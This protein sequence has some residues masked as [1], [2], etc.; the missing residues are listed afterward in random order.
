MKTILRFKGSD[1]SGNH[2][3]AGR[4]GHRGGSAPGRRGTAAPKTETTSSTLE[5]H[6]IAQAIQIA[7]EIADASGG[8]TTDAGEAAR[9]FGERTGKTLTDSQV[10]QITNAVNNEFRVENYD[11]QLVEEKRPVAAATTV[12]RP[13]RTRE[14][15][16]IVTADGIKNGVPKSVM[17]V[18]SWDVHR[19]M[20]GPDVFTFGK[21]FYYRSG[22]PEGFAADVQDQLAQADLQGEIIISGEHYYPGFVGGAK[23]FS[24]KDSFYYA[25]MKV[26]RRR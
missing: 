10:Q 18:T 3:H 11:S 7:Y 19:A 5:P 15:G 12:T 22:T 20:E 14:L 1:T 4:P 24:A 8:E 25:V 26:T 17:D 6:D 21:S 23:I 2:G 9:I 16:N 13:V